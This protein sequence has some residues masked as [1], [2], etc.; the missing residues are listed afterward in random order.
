MIPYGVEFFVGLEPIDLRGYA[1][2]SVMP[3][4]AAASD[5]VPIRSNIKVSYR[6]R[7]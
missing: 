4:W 6:S 7:S 2:S 5:S 1:E 3:S